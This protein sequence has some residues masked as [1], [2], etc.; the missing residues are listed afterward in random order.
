MSRALREM[1][2]MIRSQ[3]LDLIVEARDARMPLTSI[4]PVFEKMLDDYNA[5]A[6]VKRIVV[7]NKA[8]LADSRFQEVTTYPFSLL[9]VN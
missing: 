5:H 9:T 4:N 7:Y 6:R 1:Q 2:H 8:D 3:E